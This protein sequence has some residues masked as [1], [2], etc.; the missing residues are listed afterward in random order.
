[1]DSRHLSYPRLIV[2]VI[3]MTALIAAGAAYAASKAQLPLVIYNNG[4]GNSGFVASGWMGDTGKIQ[5]DGKCHVKPPTGTRCLR[6]RFTGSSGW[7][8]I[9]WQNPANNWGNESGGV[10]LTRAKK[11]VFWAKAKHGGLVVTFGYGLIGKR[12]AHHDSS[13]ASKKLT[14]GKHWKKY[15]I[16]LAGKNMSHII[17]GFY[18]SAAANGSPFTFYLDGVEY[19]K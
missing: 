8:G 3:S 10:N 7:G 11:L 18:W 14:L 6:I 12:K 1:M 4:G 17:T 15:T 2:L 5:Y 13:S 19:R 9:V 16:S